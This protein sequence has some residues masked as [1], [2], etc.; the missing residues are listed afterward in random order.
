VV[1]AHRNIQAARSTVIANEAAAKSAGESFKI[2]KRKYEENQVILVEYLDARTKFTNSQ[3]G[4]VIANYDLLIREAE[5][6]RTL[7]L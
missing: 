3:I 7:S 6:Q 5:L 2:I 1:D 4:L